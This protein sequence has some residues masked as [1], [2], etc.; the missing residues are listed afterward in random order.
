M[1]ATVAI[2]K[3]AAVLQILNSRVSAVDEGCVTI[4]DK[5]KKESKINFGA[6]V[7]A[8]GVAMNPLVKQIAEQLPNQNHFRSLLTDEKL[9]VLGSSGSMWA[10]GDAST[11][12]SPHALDYADELFEEGD[13]SR[14]GTLSLAELRVR[15]A[16]V[17]HQ[18]NQ[19]SCS[20]KCGLCC[21]TCDGRACGCVQ[22]RAMA[23]CIAR[24][25]WARVP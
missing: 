2:D 23:G 15:I 4:L 18:L 5:N 21:Y 16:S 20:I 13:V 25:V 10:M 11:V 6:C 9:R 22:S 14:S 24:L 7:W 17:K 12:W 8:T 3:Q 1:H 19:C